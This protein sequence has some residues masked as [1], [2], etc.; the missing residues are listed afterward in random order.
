MSSE[1]FSRSYLK[2]LPEQR[3]QQYIESLLTRRIVGDVIVTAESG[4]TSYMYEPTPGRGYN[5]PHLPITHEDYIAAFQRKFP[6]C[7]VSYQEIWMNTG[8]NT[9]NLK[10]GIVI[11]WS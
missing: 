7:T 1:T 10:K 2:G 3:K 6:E 5:P 4:L 8:A 11:D 9:K